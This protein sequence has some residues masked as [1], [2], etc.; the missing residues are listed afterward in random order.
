M[1]LLKT[2]YTFFVL[3]YVPFFGLQVCIIVYKH[4]ISVKIGLNDHTHSTILYIV[5]C[6]K[7]PCWCLKDK[8]RYFISNRV[9]NF[10]LTVTT[11][12]F[13]VF[14]PPKWSN[15]D[16]NVPSGNKAEFSVVLWCPHG[17][18]L[19]ACPDWDSGSLSQHL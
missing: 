9:Q 12:G 6:T 7:G 5:N 13:S 10:V 19:G 3:M 11:E 1:Q 8:G 15:D 2:F 17:S 4:T 14:C 16:K 18:S